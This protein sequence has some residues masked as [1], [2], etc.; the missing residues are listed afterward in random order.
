M[1]VVAAGKTCRQHSFYR[2]VCRHFQNNV[3]MLFYVILKFLLG[4]VCADVFGIYVLGVL[5]LG[6]HQILFCNFFFFFFLNYFQK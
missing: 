3:V 6:I 1:A 2:V 5:T 4:T